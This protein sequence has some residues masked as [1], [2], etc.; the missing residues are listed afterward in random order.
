MTP[1]LGQSYG[2]QLVRYQVMTTIHSMSGLLPAFLQTVTFPVAVDD[3]SIHIIELFQSGKTEDP[4]H[5][6]GQDTVCVA[7]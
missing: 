5:I 7:C 2:E 6:T 1:G 4:K 3:E